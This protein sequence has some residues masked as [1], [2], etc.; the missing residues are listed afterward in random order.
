[1]KVKTCGKPYKWDT[2]G[3]GKFGTYCVFLAV[4]LWIFVTLK[5]IIRA[6][7]KMFHCGKFTCFCLCAGSLFRAQLRCWEARQVL[8]DGGPRKAFEVLQQAASSLGKVHDQTTESFKLTQ[9]LFLYFEG[10]IHCQS[11]DY[12]KALECLQSSLD[13]TEMLL[14][15]DTNL[16]RC[17]N[18]MGNCYY[19]LGKPQKAL[20]YYTK[21][22]KMREELS[23]GSELHFDMPVYKNQ[24]GTV[25]EDQGEY[26]K[27]VECYKDA[28]RLLEELE[29]TGYE[30]EALFCRNLANVYNIQKNFLDAAE[31]AEKAY[32]IRSKRLGN[33]PDTVRSIFQLGMIQANLSEFKK[34]LDLFR[35]AWEMEKLLDPGNHSAVWKLIIEGVNDIMCDL[36]DSKERDENEKEIVWQ[37]RKSF[38]RD[39]LTFCKRFWKEEKESSQ[40][41]FTEYNKEII[42]TIMELLGGED[43]NEDAR[44]EFE[45]ER[46]WFY[47]GFQIATEEDFYQ[48]F[49]Q[50]TGNEELNAML[51]ER[52][53]LLDMI[54]DVY[55]RLDQNDKRSEHEQKKLILYRKFLLRADFV[56]EEGNEKAT[57]KS[58]V[59]ELYQ[60]LDEKESIPTF[61]ENL[62]RTW[63]TQWEES[64][65]AEETKEIMRTRKRAIDGIL[66]LCQELDKKELVKRYGGEALRFNE[67]LWKVAYAEMERY[68]MEEFLRELK[69]LASLVADLERVKIYDDAL[70]VSERK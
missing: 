7:L 58:K 51:R 66:H 52:S 40:F 13:L 47:E 45:K 16:A 65:G 1:M 60:A 28:L 59:E 61:R 29:I 26:D 25:Y 70:R 6:A 18:A 17:Y 54:I 35:K 27:A 34:A 5:F 63:L 20:E 3:C 12:K 24:I 43:E 38:R 69:D 9:G 37:E 31:F 22:L 10:E 36:L 67:R 55:S 8:E 21:A 33:H 68:T 14:K 39:A 41:G 4:T 64:K 32:S 56:G 30:D 48:T 62:L 57:L 19:G 49:D 53:E 50:E 15:V 2:L 23:E 46:L 11:K 44:I 42:D